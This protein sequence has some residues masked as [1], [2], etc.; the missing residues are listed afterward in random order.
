MSKKGQSNSQLKTDRLKGDWKAL[1]IVHSHAAGIDIGGSEHWVTINPERDEQPVRCFDCFTA[2]GVRSVAIQSTGVGNRNPA[3]IAGRG[4]RFAHRLHQ[5]AVVRGLLSQRDRGRHHRDTWVANGW[6]CRRQCGRW[7]C[8]DN[9]SR[10]SVEADASSHPDYYPQRT[11]SMKI[12]PPI[13]RKVV[14][15]FLFL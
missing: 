14:S 4:G 5:S 9:P 8:L 12:R 2:D 11:G 1:E 15:P 3:R 7:L 6:C 10:T 13:P